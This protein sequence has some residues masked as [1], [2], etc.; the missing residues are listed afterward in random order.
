MSNAT[1]IITSP[2]CTTEFAVYASLMAIFTTAFLI[3]SGYLGYYL[4]KKAP[5]AHRDK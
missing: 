2:D 5:I 4:I 3:V 1:T